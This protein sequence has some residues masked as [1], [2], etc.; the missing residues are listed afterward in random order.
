MNA[1]VQNRKY[2]SVTL[3]AMVCA[4]TLP[5]S[6]F[7]VSGPLTVQTQVTATCQSPEPEGTLRIPFDASEDFNGQSFSDP[8]EVTVTCS[9]GAGVDSVTVGVGNE[10]SGVTDRVLKN[11]DAGACFKYRLQVGDTDG[12][13]AYADVDTTVGN[14]NVTASP[15]F[16]RA[17]ITGGL[18]QDNNLDCD[19]AEGLTTNMPGGTYNDSVVMTVNFSAQ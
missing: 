9:G 17:E 14:T 15:F 12:P 11:D 19:A 16:V 10:V 8:V 7:A 4:A 13:A 3:A 1:T 5:S 6:A 18:V 2:L